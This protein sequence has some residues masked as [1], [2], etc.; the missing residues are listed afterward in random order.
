MSDCKNQLQQRLPEH[1]AKISI[2]F[3]R[4]AQF[5]MLS[6]ETCEKKID[7]DFTNPVNPVLNVKRKLNWSPTMFTMTERNWKITKL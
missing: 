2:K 3:D 1:S 7:F 6:I 5:K 4:L